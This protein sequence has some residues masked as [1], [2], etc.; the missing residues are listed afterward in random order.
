MAVAVIPAR[1]DST[2]LPGKPLRE[3]GGKPMIVRVVEQ[4]SRAQTISRAIVATD[5]E[6]IFDAVRAS[7]YEALMTS[8]AHQSG[9][10][11]IA[12]VAAELEA[13]IIVNVQGDEPLVA[14]ET[15]DLAVEALRQDAEAVVATTCEKIE[16][17]SEVLSPD[18]VKVLIDERGRA[19]Y[20]SRHAIPFPRD[21]VKRHKTL[22]RALLCEPALLKLFRKH[23]GLYAYRRPFLLEYAKWQPTVL[24]KVESLEQLRIIER[25]FKIAVVEAASRSIGVDTPEDLERVREMFAAETKA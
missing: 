23:T 12:E 13:E 24:E 15:I 16:S 19:I 2:R 1:Y 25:G 22:E 20:F 14:P 18:T 9:S 8:R 21:A 5:D 7:G 11:R 4:A 3:I 17:A 10:D 6:R